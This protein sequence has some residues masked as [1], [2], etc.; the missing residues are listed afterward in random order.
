[1]IRYAARIRGWALA[2]LPWVAAAGTLWYAGGAAAG[3]AAWMALGAA[4]FRRLPVLYPKQRRLGLPRLFFAVSAGLAVLNALYAAA[5]FAFAA[6]PRDSRLFSALIAVGN[7]CFS[8]IACEK[9]LSLRLPRKVCLGL[10]VTLCAFSVY[11]F[12]YM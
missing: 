7:S 3:M 12:F 2:A 4:V 5:D 1:M 9:A 11:L 6:I 10:G 8:L